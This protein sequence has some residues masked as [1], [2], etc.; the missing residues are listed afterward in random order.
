MIRA[1]QRQAMRS[2]L[3]HLSDSEYPSLDELRKEIDSALSGMSTDVLTE[4]LMESVENGELIIGPYSKNTLRVDTYF[5]DMPARRYS[6][7]INEDE[8]LLNNF[9]DGSAPIAAIL[10][11]SYQIYLMSGK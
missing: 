2:L 6:V 11:I 8:V 4:Y 3:V 5:P 1:E 7:Y 10:G 9:E